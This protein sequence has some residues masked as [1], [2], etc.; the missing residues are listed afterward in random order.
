[1]GRGTARSVVEGAAQRRFRHPLL[2]TAGSVE[3]N[4]ADGLTFVTPEQPKGRSALH[5]WPILVCA[6]LAA[7]GPYPRD[8]SGTLDAIERD[9]RLRIGFAE[10][11]ADDRLEAQQLVARLE[12]ATGAQAEIDRAP[13]E[14]QISRLEDGE[15]DL[16]I[17]GFREDSPW[18]SHVTV[19]EPLSRRTVGKRVLGLSPAI[20]NGENRWVALVERE[21][22]DGNGR[23]GGA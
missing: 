12:A 18:A 4:V 10:L 3:R 23:G 14:T 13:M 17:G 2:R 20:A 16:V 19:L 21:I 15:L 22:R 6:A 11:T 8:T 7:C 1:M 5:R 9:G